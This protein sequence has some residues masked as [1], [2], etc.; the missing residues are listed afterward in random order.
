MKIL[1]FL[2]RAIGL[3][4]VVIAGLFLAFSCYGWLS[5]AKKEWL[6]RTWSIV[7][8]KTTG[9]Y[10]KREG[11]AIINGSVL[12]VANHVSWID[13]FIINSQRA[14]SFIAKSEIRKWPV[15]GWL[16]ESVGTIFIERGSRQAVMAINDQ[17][18]GYFQNATSIGLFPEG[19][20]SDGLS[21]LHI[22]SGL[23]DGA[24]QAQI[25]IQPIAL[26]FYH[27]NIRSGHVAFVGEQTLVQNIWVLLSSKHVQVTVRVLPPVTQANEQVVMSRQELA[28]KI[29][30]VLLHT[31]EQQG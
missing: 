11:E 4:F 14:T 10:I 30:Q 27:N 6:L 28:D 23:L 3:L 5:K 22:Y 18:K 20:T 21:V 13:I 17:V 24:M 26:Q 25:P 8:M 12:L 16:V 1:L 2:V 31:V 9:V 15:I 19:T 7:L 29:R